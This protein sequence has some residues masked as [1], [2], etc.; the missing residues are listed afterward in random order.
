MDVREPSAAGRWWERLIL[1]IAR[2]SGPVEVHRDGQ[3]VTYLLFDYDG[4]V[5]VVARED[6]DSAVDEHSRGLRGPWAD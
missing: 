2:A 4:H 6:T 3:E 1:A 5:E